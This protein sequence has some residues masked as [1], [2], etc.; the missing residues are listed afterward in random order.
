MLISTKLSLGASVVKNL[1]Y[2]ARNTGLI[3]QAVEQPTPHTPTTEPT[4]SGAH[5]PQPESPRTAAKDPACQ[6]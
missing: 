4:G 6:T 2:N 3:P 1:P 5:V